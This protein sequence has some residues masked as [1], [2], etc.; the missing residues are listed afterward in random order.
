VAREEYRQG[1]RLLLAG[2]GDEQLA[3]RTELLS[4][5]L[6]TADFGDLRRQSE[7]HLLDGK[8]V[9]FWL[10]TDRGAVRYRMEIS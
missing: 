2:E 9:T 6:E 10:Y 3:G 8:Q 1:L 4:R 5:F 7:R